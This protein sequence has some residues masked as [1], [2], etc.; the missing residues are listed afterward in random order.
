MRFLLGLERLTAAAV[1]MWLALVYLVSGS[2]AAAEGVAA[3]RF[4]MPKLARVEARDT[5]TYFV[6]REEYDDDHEED[7]FERVEIERMYVEMERASLE[8]MYGAMEMVEKTAS[9]VGDDDGAAALA[10]VSINDVFEYD[11]A[12]QLLEEVVRSAPSKVA[13]RL[14]RFQLAEIHGEH[15]NLGEVRKQL[16]AIIFDAE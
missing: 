8:A 2:A 5:E 11:E 13:R 9:I 1:P 3:D 10:V 12:V 6:H 14:A 4:A 16:R 15:D 7:E